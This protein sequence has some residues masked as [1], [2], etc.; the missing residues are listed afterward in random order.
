[1]NKKFICATKECCSLEKY[2]PA[3]YIR[4]S[5]N[6]DFVPKKAEI[7]ICGLGFYALYI[8]GRKHNKGRVG[9]VYKQS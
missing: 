5:F 6:I 8:N 4:K 7:L 1:M 3:P 2:V 9:T